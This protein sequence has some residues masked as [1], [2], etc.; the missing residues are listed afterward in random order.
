MAYTPLF[1]ITQITFFH[2]HS[3]FLMDNLF[4]FLFHY[5][6]VILFHEYIS[7]FMTLDKPLLGHLNPFPDH[8]QVSSIAQ[9]LTHLFVGYHY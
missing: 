8:L 3:I 6:L 7:G 5:Y 2:M 1:D 9:V 4:H